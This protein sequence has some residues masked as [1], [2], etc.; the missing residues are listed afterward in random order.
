MNV[1]RENLSRRQLLKLGAV[2]GLALG[3]APLLN[4]CSTLA[5]AAPGRELED[6]DRGAGDAA[7]GGQ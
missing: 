4:A 1:D 2:S 3:G 6:A 5:P 7:Q